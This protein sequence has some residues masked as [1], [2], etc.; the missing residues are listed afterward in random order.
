MEY[1][2]Q[3]AQWCG[4]TVSTFPNFFQVFWGM[5]IMNLYKKWNVGIYT[6]IGSN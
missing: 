1:F 6:V 5:E 2:R 3:G 4:L